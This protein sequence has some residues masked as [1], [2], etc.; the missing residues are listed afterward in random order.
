MKHFA[1]GIVV[2][3]A[4][5]AAFASSAVAN[6][7][8]ETWTP[9]YDV[10]TAQ[11]LAQLPT[12]TQE[13]WSPAWELPASFT[14]GTGTTLTGTDYIT[15]S[16]GGF[17]DEFITKDGAIY[18][19]NQLF[20]G[21][22]NLYYDPAG[23]GPAV[24][25]MKTPFGSFDMSSM[26]STFA[27]A[28]LPTVNAETVGNNIVVGDGGGLRITQALGLSNGS[29]HWAGGPM[30][31]SVTPMET[32]DSSLVW[33]VPAM[34]TDGSGPDVPTLTGTEYVTSP[35]DVEFVDKAGD[36]FDQHAF[37]YGLFPVEN[38]YYDP[39]DGPAVDEIQTI[40]GNIDLS[41]IASWFAPAD[42]ADLVTPSPLADL[43]DAGLYSALDLL[44]GLTP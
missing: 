16:G 26:A 9:D 36:V 10:G 34:F 32:P 29:D 20:P 37:V 33:S 31:T 5:A 19:Q 4:V 42:V 23:D 43:A 17:N 2:G 30:A 38:L 12:L 44:T 22:T 41:P 8:G 24:D 3:G 13:G 35:T 18:D 40:F 28:E 21:F 27:P 1:W 15:L 11:L 14:S 6:A 39:V 7:T 25:A